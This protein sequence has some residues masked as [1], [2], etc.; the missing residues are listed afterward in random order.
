MLKVPQEKIA[1]LE[2]YGFKEGNYY[3]PYLG[4]SKWGLLIDGDEFY[5]VAYVKKDGT[6]QIAVFS[7]SYHAPVDLDIVY[8][9]IKDGVLVKAEE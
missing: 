6:F 7:E 3:S 9:M 5:C 2:K 4:Y 1:E 8:D